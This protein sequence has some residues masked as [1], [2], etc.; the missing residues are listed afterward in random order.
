MAGVTKVGQHNNLK[1]LGLA[2]HDYHDRYETL[3]AG[4]RYS[5]TGD[6][7]H[8]WQTTL[9]PFLEE[10][11]LYEQLDL[12]K[13]WHDPNNREHFQKSLAVFLNPGISGFGRQAEDS[14][15]APS[16]YA[17]NI[18]VLKPGQGLKFQ[19]IRDGTSN[20]FLA[21]EV[22]SN[23]KA[24]GDPTNLRDPMLGINRSSDGFG[25]PFKGG[26]QML[27]SDG[28]VRF[29]T[30][31]IDLKIFQGLGTPAGGEEIDNDSR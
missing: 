6:A 30:N 31:E 22:N 12:S 16:H 27:M 23:F 25:S 24:W 28:S 17:G 9:L 1:Q 26:A 4:I 5:S 10:E 29:I 7:L 11:R 2:C 15:P 18:R 14:Q 20:T 3:P 19:E 21:G 8:S 13:P